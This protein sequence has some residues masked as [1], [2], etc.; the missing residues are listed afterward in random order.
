M[1]TAL[2]IDQACYIANVGLELVPYPR[3]ESALL[4]SLAERLAADISLVRV[5]GT[6]LPHRNL[7]DGIDQQVGRDARRTHLHMVG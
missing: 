2:N 3:I 4:Q 5:H 1:S 7:A 6:T